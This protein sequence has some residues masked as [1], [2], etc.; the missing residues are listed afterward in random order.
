MDIPNGEGA[1]IAGMYADVGLDVKR[2]G[3]TL[4]IPSTALVADEDGTRV[5]TIVD[6][7]I[8]WT[9]VTVESDLGDRLSISGGLKETDTVV[10]VPSTKLIDGLPVDIVAPTLPPASASVAAAPAAANVAS[11]KGVAPTGSA[12]AAP[13]TK[14]P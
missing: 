2:A 4:M 11:P 9:V 3:Q 1:L 5:A 13:E 6:G 12:A 10:T 7:K 8:K 14:Q